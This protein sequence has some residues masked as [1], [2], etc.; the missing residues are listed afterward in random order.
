MIFD[1]WEGN[2]DERHF[3]QEKVRTTAKSCPDDHEAARRLEAE[4]WAYYVERSGVVAPFREVAAREGLART[5]MRN[6]AEYLIRLWTEP[7]LKPKR[8]AP[9]W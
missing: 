1:Y 9:G 3:W 8:R 7:R 4:L 2:P 6:L 5:S